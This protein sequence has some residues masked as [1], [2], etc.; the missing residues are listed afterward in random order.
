[1]EIEAETEFKKRLL[2]NWGLHDIKATTKYL[3]GSLYLTAA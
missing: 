1:M 3:W 2:S